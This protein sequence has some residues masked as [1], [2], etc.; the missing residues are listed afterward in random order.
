MA[1]RDVAPFDIRRDHETSLWKGDTG[2]M[3]I[4]A[5]LMTGAMSPG[6]LIREA[7][8]VREESYGKADEIISEANQ[9]AMRLEA[10]ADA[11]I[12]AARSPSRESKTA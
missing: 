2:S 5:L 9:R 11:M 1:P 8:S 10:K 4:Q 12:A 6:E 7:K 3:S